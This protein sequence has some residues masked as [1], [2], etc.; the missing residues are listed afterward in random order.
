MRVTREQMQANRTRILDAAGS[1]FREKGFDAVSVAEVMKAAGLT[2]GG[3]YGHFESKD[4][5]I[6]KTIAHIFA[7]GAQGP[8]DLTT[9]L[10]AYLSPLHRD[11]IAK[12]C[13][14]AALVA[15]V[16]RQTPAARVAMT[17]GFNAQIDRI[18]SAV[19]Q[20]ESCHARRAAIGAWAALVGAIVLA[21]TTDD[22]ALSDEILKETRDW[23][24]NRTTEPQTD[25][26]TALAPSEA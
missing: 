5:L 15:D 2:H 11:S 4:D 16:R 25:G 22:P 7:A 13:P 14:T 26:D 8:D 21:R 19:A 18:T 20:T 1:L 24:S 6:A 17:A 3:F 9:F 12:G 10:D 23:I